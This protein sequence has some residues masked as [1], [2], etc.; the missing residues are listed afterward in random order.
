MDIQQYISSGI[1]ESYVMGLCTPE[2]EREIDQLRNQYPELDKAI[3]DCEYKLEKNLLQHTTLPDTDTDNKIL[4][5][6]EKLEK[7]AT[8]IPLSAPKKGW[9]KPLAIAAS[10]L[11]LISI[12]LNYYLFQE[13]KKQD[14]ITDYKGLPQSDY[15]IMND[16]TI[17]PVAMYG[18]GSHA[19]C[20]C[21]MFWD[22]KTGKAYVMIHH[23]VNYS[24]AKEFQLWAIVDGK[25]V[26]V[27]FINEKIRGRFIELNNVP[28]GATAFSVTLEN[29]GGSNTPTESQTYLRGEI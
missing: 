6:I 29:A 2:E 1:L 7:P 3:F 10:I 20:R 18:V 17:T 22:K 21:T 15:L 16:P 26:S 13:T 28:A 19:I 27:G 9:M 23:L 14:V 12:G 25:P 5:T 4:S 24:S 8:V 11:L